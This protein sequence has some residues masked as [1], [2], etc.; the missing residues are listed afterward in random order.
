MA[1]Y[2]ICM[3]ARKDMINTRTLLVLANALIYILPGMVLIGCSGPEQWQEEV[4]LSTGEI[5]NIQREVEHRGG[6]G[7]W[8]G[9]AGSCKPAARPRLAGVVALGRPAQQ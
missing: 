5:I 2:Q 8:P 4:K 9:R 3:E 6:G 1:P 7:A